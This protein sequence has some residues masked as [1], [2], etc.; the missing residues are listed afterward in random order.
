LEAK[1]TGG[2]IVKLEIDIN[3][4]ELQEEITGIIAKKITAAWSAERN[5][6]K[7]TIADAVKEVVY[8]QKEMII[9]K[10]IKRATTE[11]VRKAMPKLMDKMMEGKR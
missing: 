9:D 10:V 2:R 6:L 8:S 7:H 11:I 5:M 1:W 4:R 3:D